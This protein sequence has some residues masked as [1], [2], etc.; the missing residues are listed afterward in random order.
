MKTVEMDVFAKYKKE[1]EDLNETNEELRRANT[2][3]EE[4]LHELYNEYQWLRYQLSGMPTQTEVLKLRQE[5]LTLKKELHFK[6]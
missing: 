6:S 3:L 2:D 1:I 5:M 4:R